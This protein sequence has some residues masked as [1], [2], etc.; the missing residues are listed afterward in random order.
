M[1]GER[2]ASFSPF[3]TSPPNNLL[4]ISSFLLTSRFYFTIVLGRYLHIPSFC[5]W[6]INYDVPFNVTGPPHICCRFG[7]VEDP[8]FFAWDYG[9]THGHVL[10]ASSCTCEWKASPIII[11]RFY[12]DATSSWWRPRTARGACPSWSR[13]SLSLVLSHFSKLSHL[14]DFVASRPCF[15]WWTWNRLWR[16]LWNWRHLHFYMVLNSQRWT[17]SLIARSDSLTT[18]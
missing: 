15:W 14:N 4:R 11:F 9:V 8:F 13:S 17:L 16:L 12:V 10:R 1:E 6:P 7:L 2:E 5:P 3:S 18:S